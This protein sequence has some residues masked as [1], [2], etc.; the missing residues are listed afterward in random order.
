MSPD[1]LD[2]MCSGLTPAYGRGTERLTVPL[3]TD[4]AGTLSPRY[5]FSRYLSQYGRTPD[6]PRHLLAPRQD[7]VEP[8]TVQVTFER[9]P[10]APA[11][12]TAVRF[13]AGWPG[14]AALA[15]ELPGRASDFTDQLRITGLRPQPPA[16][17]TPDDWQL[18]A[19]L[20]NLAKLLWVIGHDYQD[21]TRR[22]AE[23]ASQRNASAARGA[24]LDLLGLDLGAPRFPPRPYSWDDATL[25]L[26]HLADQ[27]APGSTQVATVADEGSRY[28]APGPPGTTTGHPGTVGGA[29]RWGR[30][31]PFAPAF[32]FGAPSSGITIGDSPDFALPATAE[33][34]V[35]AVVRPDRGSTG[36]GAVLAKRNP[37]N[38]AAAAGWSLT[39]GSYRGVDHNPRLALGDGTTEVELFADQDLGDGLFHHLAGTVR[40]TPTE[41]VVRLH[42]DGVEVGSRRLEQLG[43]LG[44]TEPIVIGQGTE[45][46]ATGTLPAQYTGLVA[47]V[48]ISR[49]ARTSFGPVT[50]EDDE[51]YRARLHIFQRW[52]VPTP[53]ALQAVLNRTAGPVAGNPAAFVV[54]ETPARLATGSLDLRVLPA[55]LTAGQCIAADGDR[56]S[57]EARAVGT[58]ADEPDFDP[59]WLCRYPD[60]PGLAFA[61][62]GPG[63]AS[64]E[65]NRLMQLTVRRALD[66]LLAR[67]DGRGGTLTVLRAYDPAATDLHAVGRALQ[68]RHSTL[69][70]GELGVQAH[71]AGFGWVC[72]TADGLIRALQPP[73]DAFA[74]TLPAD[75]VVGGPRSDGAPDLTAGESVPLGLDPPVDGLAGAEVR[76]SVTRGGPGSAEVT[77][78]APGAAR[79]SAVLQA[80]DAGDVTVTVDVTVAGHTRT[81][82]RALRIGLPSTTLTAGLSISR[83]GLLGATEAEAAGTVTDDFDESYLQLRTDDLL[84]P[85][86]PVDYGSDPNARRMQPA[87]GAAL[88]RLLDLLTPFSGS[89]IVLSAFTPPDPSPASPGLANQGRVLV[90]RYASFSPPGHPPLP[91]TAGALAAHAFAAG[92]D[93]VSVQAPAVPGGPETVRVAV[94]PGEQLGVAPLGPA[95]TGRTAPAPPTE[96]RVGQS[97]DVGVT[98]R[99]D[100]VAACFT[101]DG[102]RLCLAERGSHRVAVFQL[103]AAQP[104]DLPVP[105]FAASRILAPLP[106]ALAVAAG[107]LFVAHQAVGLLAVLD[108]GSLATLATVAVPGAVALATDGTR[109]F[110][111]CTGDNSLRAYDPQTLQQTGSVALPGVPGALAVSPGSPVL[112]V[113]LDGGRFCLVIRSAM[114][115]QG[116][117]I[118]TGPGTGT[119]CA[120]LTPDGTKLY[121]GLTG[122]GPTGTGTGTVLVYPTGA[123][124][125][126]ATL[127]AFPPGTVPL[128]M[129]AATDQ[130][131]LYVAT[132]GTAAVP[133]RVHVVDT[134]TDALLPLPFAPGGG[135][136]VLAASPPGAGYLPCLLTAPAAG[137]TLLVADQTPLG[138]TPPQ[139]PQPASRQPL[140]PDGGVSLA[141]SASPAGPGR[142]EPASAG[143]PVTGLTGLAPGPVRLRA[144]YLRG[145]GLLP[146]QCEVRLSPD[147]DARPDVV[148]SKEQYDLVLNILNWFHP[149]GVEFRT[150][151]IRTHV[152]ELS[153]GAPG[154]DLLPAYTFPTYHT[155][156]PLPSRF[157]RPDQEGPP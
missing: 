19:L 75:P 136:R 5:D 49:S 60:R 140:G 127:T 126:T 137:G 59:G 157:T 83:A 58:L 4:G 67:L 25:A 62:D 70:T 102:S 112:A 107:R 149:I 27:P 108:P 105:A 144:D 56:L 132:T 31:G 18:T 15:V 92:F 103:S 135:T 109:I 91:L 63:A 90:L 68:L 22:L 121:V 14:G 39:L 114:Q 101:A 2:L 53:D 115:L 145:S 77:P 88:D 122:T 17:Q 139:P 150:E 128:A 61:A 84:D 34:T 110:A 98:P 28:A 134:A 43:A 42:L 119:R 48:R 111:A 11:E 82:S 44:N 7:T 100:P 152:R 51:Q 155:S 99:A 148:I 13:P 97:L 38:A 93:H 1:F 96:L 45:S 118:G 47:E 72:C 71:A 106:G 89:L 29:A 30:T 33:L 26:Y 64:P 95:T 154:T 81:G 6:A 153:A 138:R 50:G 76:W 9:T 124:A 23:V 21:L 130:R 87:A 16:P 46:T 55:P 113:L 65:G 41:T 151:R 104:T 37:L 20:G 146:Y 147:L 74:V 141:W 32:G 129:C 142:A 24:S 54:D 79:G 117:P 125:P 131:H 73:G 66:A 3:D 86:R 69:D 35:E 94:A 36:P 123:T 57:T 133:G 120:A 10:G 78:G 156:A 143:A 85:S 40:R 12:S 80:V 52:L 116:G 8:L